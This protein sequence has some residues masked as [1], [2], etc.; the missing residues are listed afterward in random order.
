[1]S[2]MGG[3][4]AGDEAL[5]AVRDLRVRFGPVT[6][7]DGVSLTVSTGPFG[8][9]VVGESGSGKTPLGRAIL[10]LVPAAGGTVRFDGQDVLGLRGRRLR[11]YRGGGQ[12]RLPGSAASRQPPA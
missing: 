9:A 3:D 8:M 11:E 5:L 12:R 10:R 2:P 6:A 4:I 1:V 7:V